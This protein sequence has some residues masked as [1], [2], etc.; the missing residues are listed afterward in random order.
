MIE[1]LTLGPRVITLDGAEAPAELRHRKN[2]ALLVYLARSPGRMRSREHLVGLF[3]SDKP[4]DRARHSLREAIR[5][6]RSVLGEDGLE[7]ESDRVRLA[8]DAVH[9]DIDTL[10]Q[11]EDSN[12]SRGA[13]E[14]VRGEFL[15]GFT[16]PA[17]S[18]FED[19]LGSERLHWRGRSVGVLIR[20]AEESLARGDSATA[21]VNAEQQDVVAAVREITGGT[22][23][24]LVVEAV[25]HR[26]HR[27]NDCFNL[28]RHGDEILFFGVPPEKINDVNWRILFDKNASIHTSI[29]PSFER[30]FP[31]AMRWIAEGRIDVTPVITHHLPLDQIQAAFDLFA[32]RRDGALKVFVDFPR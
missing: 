32:E 7:L 26:E 1:I 24:D 18:A 25:G 8:N 16:V 13:A 27:I 11:L 19:W 30:D 20:Y 31:L 6:L 21:T 14:L 17:A 15:E 2:F 3:W 9:L 10:Q 22:L 28:V 5:I 12:D 29:G 23:A 4:E